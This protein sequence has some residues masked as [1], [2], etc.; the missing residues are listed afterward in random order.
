MFGKNFE[1][2]LDFSSPRHF[3][4][5]R[6]WTSIFKTFASTCAVGQGEP[7]SDFG[8]TSILAKHKD[9]PGQ[10]SGQVKAEAEPGGS[11]QRMVNWIPHGG[12][13]GPGRPPT[14][15]E[16]SLD[17]FAKSRGFKWQDVARDR[18]AWDDWK[19]AFV[20]DDGNGEED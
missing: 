7:P 11:T 8:K 10:R 16:D 17:S 4:L 3:A 6:N 20:G 5:A 15:W 14:R 13:R 2:E 18:R 19:S 1:R 9:H 12:E